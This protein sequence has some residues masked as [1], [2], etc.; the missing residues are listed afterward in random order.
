MISVILAF[1]MGLLAVAIVI[2][3]I[4]VTN[5]LSLSVLERK[6]ETA[7][8]RSI[9]LSAR[10]LRSMLAVEGIFIALVGTLCGIGLGFIYGWA[11]SLT[12]LMSFAHVVIAV[13]WLHTAIIIAVGVSAGLL[14][15]LIP[16]RSA[17][18]DS[19][20]EALGIE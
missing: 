12:V 20:V 18:K 5:T 1:V 3:L 9:G 6:R 17:M 8:L 16:A 15:S 19:P 2:A 7:T 13:P 10:Q 11:G 4:G 14:A